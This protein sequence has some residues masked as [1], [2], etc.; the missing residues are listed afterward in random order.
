MF[1]SFFCLQEFHAENVD[2]MRLKSKDVV[3]SELDSIY[4]TANC[5]QACLNQCMK[6]IGKDQLMQL[7]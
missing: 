2:K 1:E 5:N 6:I 7:V 4:E 3:G